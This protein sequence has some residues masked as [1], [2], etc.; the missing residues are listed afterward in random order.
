M[1]E[2]KLGRWA[3][4]SQ[5]LGD[6]KKYAV[7]RL[8]DTSAVDH[9]GN[10]E[11]A[12]DYMVSR[13]E[14]QAIADLMNS[15][16][17]NRDGIEIETHN[18]TWYVIDEKVHKGEHIYLLES[19]EWGDEVECLIVKGDLTVLHDEVYNGFDD[20]HEKEALEDE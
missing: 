12:T 18:G 6:T 1:K 10:R 5:F 13:E 8:R 11:H 3:V 15:E 9:S 20:L 4:T 17:Y 16:I 2:N 7:Y 19:E 14:A